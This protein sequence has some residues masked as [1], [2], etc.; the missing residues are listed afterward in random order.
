MKTTMLYQI[1]VD[2]GVKSSLGS[3]WF[4]LCTRCD[5]SYTGKNIRYCSYDHTY[6]CLT[7]KASEIGSHRRWI[8]IPPGPVLKMKAI[9]TSP[10][11][12]GIR[13]GHDEVLHL[14]V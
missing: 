8:Y 13:V 10:P 14:K 2:D 5:E 3:A 1:G 11:P 6:R 12:L 7:W 9:V 4:S